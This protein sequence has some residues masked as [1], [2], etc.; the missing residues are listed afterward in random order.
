MKLLEVKVDDFGGA[1]VCTHNYP[2]PI[3]T[4]EH[5]VYNLSDGY[6][7]PSRKA[8]RDGWKLIR[9]TNR[10]QRFVW[11]WVFGERPQRD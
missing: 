2:C 1:P 6:F 7:K 11:K 4:E 5:A 3:Y 10:F 9:I 8:Q